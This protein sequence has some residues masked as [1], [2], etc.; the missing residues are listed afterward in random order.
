MRGEHLSNDHWLD[1]FRLIGLPR[2]TTLER[3]T[4]QDLLSVAPLIAANLAQ[5]KVGKII[6]FTFDCK[7]LSSFCKFVL[8]TLIYTPTE[9]LRVAC[10]YSNAL[11]YRVATVIAPCFVL[12]G[13][14]SAVDYRQLEVLK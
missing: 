6:K 8:K 12:L 3:L 14:I 7:Q 1:L 4:F 13:F 9:G 5:L 2:G 11:P 10:Y